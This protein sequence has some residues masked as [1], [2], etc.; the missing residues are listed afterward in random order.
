MNWM[1]GEDEVGGGL[2]K[3][4]VLNVTA[5]AGD[6]RM[7][8][9]ERQV[10]VV[11]FDEQWLR[12]SWRV[13]PENLFS[14]QAIGDSMEPTISDGEFILV[15]KDRADRKPGEGVY[16]IR[17]DG[18]ILVKRLQRLPGHKI[19]V[20]SDNE[21]LYDP[22][23]IDLADEAQDFKILGRVVLVHGLRRV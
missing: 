5:S 14:I 22:I 9:E 10:G 23:E 15:S 18:D 7:V 3:L 6:G 11:G 12:A 19:K 8:W 16:V 17:L 1:T 20:S 2:I 4:P 21:D 13:N